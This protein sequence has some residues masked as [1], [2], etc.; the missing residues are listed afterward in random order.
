MLQVMVVSP[1]VHDTLL[2]GGYVDCL[3]GGLLIEEFDQGVR[4]NRVPGVV[5]V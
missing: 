4:F 1:G 3:V 5:L 2:H